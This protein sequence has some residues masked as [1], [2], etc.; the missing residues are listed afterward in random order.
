[1][2]TV[3]T[4][5]A[6]GIGRVDQDVADRAV[7]AAMDHGVNH[8]DVAPRYGDAE[9][10]LAPWMREIRGRIFLGEKT[11][12]RTRDA[13][14]ADL[15]QSLER[16]GVER[17]DLYQLHSV[18]KLA[19]LDLC[20]GKGGA[21]EALVEA[22]EQG[23]VRWLGVTGHTH[24]APRTHL[25]ALRRFDFDTVMFPLNFVLWADPDYRRDAE[26]LLAECRAR[27]VGVHIIKTVAKD[28]W[29]DRPRTHTTWYEPF[30][31]QGIIDRAVAFV[32]TRPVTTLTSVGDVTVLPRVL[33]AADRFR[34]LAADAEQALVAEA[35]RYHSPFVG[36]WA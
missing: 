8:V 7:Q 17:F 24:D 22:R 21:L 11:A 1:M 31:D 35:E 13:A 34:P 20:T 12:E 29:G 30:T 3:V 4:F 25:E 9:L 19:D 26:A 10:R 23:L 14:K 5:G 36:T 15:H 28:P 18:G 33:D 2:S 6:A 16:L 27:D 32:L